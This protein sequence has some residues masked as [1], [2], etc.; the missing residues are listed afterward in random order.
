MRLHK[1]NSVYEEIGDDITYFVK[2]YKLAKKENISVES[3]VKLLQLVYEDNYIGLSS[4]EKGCRWRIDEIHEIDMQIEKS[5]KHLYL[6]NDEI[7]SAKAL[8]NS[9]H[10]L[11]ERKRQ[12]AEQLNNYISRLETVIS[13]FKNNNEEYLKV[14][15]TIEE[16]VRSVL[17]DGKVLLQ[18]A[19]VS[20]IEAL[21]RNLGKYNNLLVGNTESSTSTPAQNLLLSH[22]ED[23]KGMI[24]D[25]SKSLYERLLI[26]LTNSII[27]NTVG[28]SSLSNSS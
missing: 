13:R 28:D 17:T 22:I 20:I 1:L 7:A 8:L 26:H 16:E 25:E 4:F 14:K 6:V 10:L 19:L 2:L 12:E 15:Q 11:G 24:L 27:D 23:Y 9:Y 18:F 3:V 21:R 5:K